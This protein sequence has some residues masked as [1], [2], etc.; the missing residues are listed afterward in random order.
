[1]SKPVGGDPAQELLMYGANSIKAEIIDM[2]TMLMVMQDNMHMLTHQAV[3]RF[4]EWIP[5]FSLYLERY[6]L[7][8][9]D[10]IFRWVEGKAGSLKGKL[11]P[12]QR[13]M[14]RGR[15]QR[16][17][18]DVEETQDTFVPHVPAGQRLSALSETV[19]TLTNDI[20]MFFEI[21]SEIV[22]PILR[23]RCSKSDIVKSRGRIVRHVVEHV[24]YEDFL[25]LYTRWM[26]PG[27]LLEWK[28]SVLLPCDFKFFS[29]ST[30]EKDMDSA[31]YQ[32]AAGFAERLEEESRDDI[33]AN[34]QSKMD[35]ERARQTRLQML[36]EGLDAEV[37]EEEEYEDEDDVDESTGFPASEAETVRSS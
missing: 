37:A 23:E 12:A 26:P 7:V 15:I 21:V 5:L 8:E 24:G 20:I 34:K 11:S 2:N 33:E 17:L 28:T 13:M 16:E 3:E 35:F 9:E 22:P 6:M 19:D 29:Y 27:D 4:F 25:A 32:I 14:I 36:Q 31:H 30:W 1:M 18:Q 10:L